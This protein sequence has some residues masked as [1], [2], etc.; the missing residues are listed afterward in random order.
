MNG[1]SSKFLSLLGLLFFTT[2]SACSPAG[3]GGDGNAV[4]GEPPLAGAKIGGSFALTNQDGGE[5]SDSDFAGQYRIMYFGFSYCPDICPTDLT[6]LMLG[7]KAAEKNDPA[8]AQK[9]QPIFVSVDPG[10]DTPAVVKQYVSSF[11]PRLI[12]LTGT[13]EQIDSIAEKFLIIHEKREVEGASEYLIDHSRQAYLMGPQGEPI[14]LLSFDG[15]PD[16]IADEIAQ[17]VS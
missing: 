9:V 13:Q 6:N 11:H 10:R 1:I 5:T 7:L 2:L 17:W 4:V 16:Q 14:A 12:G 3:S 15:P 8:I